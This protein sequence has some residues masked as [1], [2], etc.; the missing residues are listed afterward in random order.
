MGSGKCVWEEEWLRGKMEGWKEN[1]RGR[2]AKRREEGKTVYTLSLCCAGYGASVHH[3]GINV[4]QSSAYLE[5]FFRLRD[6]SFFEGFRGSDLGRMRSRL[7]GR[8]K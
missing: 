6:L 5:I 2:G 4:V 7:E 8:R 3:T 1:E